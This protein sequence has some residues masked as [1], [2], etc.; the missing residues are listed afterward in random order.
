[1]A[2]T[3]SSKKDA[4]YDLV[5][6]LTKAEKRN[7]KLYATRQSGNADAKFIALFDAIDSLTE[8]DEAKILKKRFYLLEPKPPIYLK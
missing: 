4:L 5:K 1:M 8:Y 7:F 2:P 6:S 3:N